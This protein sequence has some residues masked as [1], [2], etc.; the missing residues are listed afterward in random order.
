M[1]KHRYRSEGR[2]P[3][4]DDRPAYRGERDLPR[5][6]GFPDR[7]R[8]PMGVILIGIALWSALA[9]GAFV[10]VDPVLAWFGGAVGPLADAGTGAARWFGLGQQAAALCDVA[11]VDGLAG[12]LIGLVRTVAKPAIV[13]LWALGSLALLAAPA[14]L[15]RLRGGLRASR[16]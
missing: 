13:I 8:V 7:P 3:D 9:F 5:R 6:D 10:L 4:R 11:N 16:H 2:G 15:S 1:G 14:I 12:G